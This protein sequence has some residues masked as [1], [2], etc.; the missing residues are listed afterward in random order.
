M[1]KQ[2]ILVTTVALLAGCAPGA[3]DELQGLVDEV[4]PVEGEMIEC[5]WGTTWG[6]DSG[7]YYDCFYL[8]PGSL[9]DVGRAVL[10]RLAERG[11]I[12]T[13]RMDS[14]TIELIGA[15]DETMFY[16]DILARGFVHGRNIEESDV[17]V[18][19]GH[20]LIEVAAFEDDAGVQP[21]RLCAY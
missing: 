17:D 11:F 21:G 8:V 18:P 16:A 5:N 20:V 12:V 13:C 19:R 14:H 3:N 6:D 1:R 7:S 4:A 15:R 2:L 9:K 10:D